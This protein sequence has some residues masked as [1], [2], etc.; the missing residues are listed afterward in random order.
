M[1]KEEF[2]KLRLEAEAKLRS[3]KSA[4]QPLAQKDLMELFHELDVYR[5]ELEMQNDELRKTQTELEASRLRYADL[6]EFAPAPYLTLSDKGL[7]TE[8]NLT[9]VTRLKTQRER[10][11]GK[12]F[13]LFIEGKDRDAHYRHLKE[14]FSRK[15]PISCE[16]RLRPKGKEPFHAELMSC[17]FV[18]PGGER[19]CSTTFIN[20]GNRKTA[21]RLL[22]EAKEELALKVAERTR[23]LQ[24]KNEELQRTASNLAK[25]QHMARL[26]SWEWD[27]V[28]KKLSCSDEAYR[29]FGH[30]GRNKKFGY[31]AF[32][33]TVHP[34]DRRV[35]KKAV[36]EA[37]RRKR[38]FELDHRTILPDGSVRSIVHER[39]EV[40]LNDEKRPVLMKGIVQDI[41]ERKMMEEQ[42]Q[43][44]R[45]AADTASIAKSAFLANM[46]HEI[47]SPMQSIV[48]MIDMLSD[49]PMTAEQE[50]CIQILKRSGDHLINLLSDILQFSKIEAGHISVEELDFNLKELIDKTTRPLEAWAKEKKL[51]F[52]SKY[53]SDLP[54]L[55]RGDPTKLCQILVNIISNAIKFTSEG[56]VSL[57]IKR[58]SHSGRRKNSE[59][60]SIE[61]LFT[62]SDTGTGIPEDKIDMVFDKFVQADSSITR[63][64]GG[65]GLGTAICKGLV[66][67][68]QKLWH[69]IK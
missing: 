30:D 63:K 49:M 35:V 4:L 7:I 57:E 22:R 13:S 47:R 21:E 19:F 66:G 3:K 8:A 69:V 36:G 14:V 29:I 10:I 41:T 31:R 34:E 68:V 67:N 32:L 28:G 26:G 50:E 27:I 65:T 45:I 42:L 60:E 64:F 51:T 9:A 54:D 44:A 17:L 56:E 39:V 48:L 40:A 1:K 24:E 33:K 37:L 52:T 2:Q 61:L 59:G 55:L 5:T 58:S 23:Q 16:L 38:D 46:S 12:P 11:L 53:G 62:V 43:K 6:Y 18:A 25:A 15:E 20:I